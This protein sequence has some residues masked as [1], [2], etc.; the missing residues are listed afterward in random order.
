MLENVHAYYSQFLPLVNKGIKE[1][2]APIE[3]RLEV[4]LLSF[5]LNHNCLCF[6]DAILNSSWSVLPADMSETAFDSAAHHL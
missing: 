2:L 1:G 5:L 3:K 6:E 4:E